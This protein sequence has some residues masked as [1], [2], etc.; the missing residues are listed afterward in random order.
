MKKWFVI[1]VRPGYEKKVAKGLEKLRLE[2]YC[3]LVK[4]VRIWSDRK[5]TIETPLIKSYVFINCEEKERPL[6]FSVPGVMRYLFWLGKPAIV[7]ESQMQVLKEWVEEDKVDD[8]VYAQWKPGTKTVIG[9][10]P[11]KGKDAVVRHIGG[12]QVSLILED[13]GIVVKAK[14]KD[15]V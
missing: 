2:V 6:A 9:K 13:L 7:R 1:Q 11:L 4:E 12:N 10:G 15:V 14:L 5:K 3:P 8:M